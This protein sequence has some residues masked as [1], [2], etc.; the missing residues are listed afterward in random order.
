MQPAYL[1]DP[2]YQPQT[3]V[4]N[5]FHAQ[6]YQ[7]GYMAGQPSYPVYAPVAAPTAPPPMIP[8][9]P[10]PPAHGLTN[11]SMVRVKQAFVRSLD[12]ELGKSQL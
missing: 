10:A 3:P 4:H 2:G 11:G 8:A 6:Q 1:P 12:D 9:A 7:P 5:S